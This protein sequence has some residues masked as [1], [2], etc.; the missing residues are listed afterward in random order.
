MLGL[1]LWFLAFIRRKQAVGGL[2]L[3]F[4]LQLF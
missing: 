2:L 1:V 3:L 4:F